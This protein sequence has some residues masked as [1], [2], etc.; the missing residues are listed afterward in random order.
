MF[1]KQVD[2]SA[3]KRLVY[4]GADLLVEWRNNKQSYAYKNV[5]NEVAIKVATAQSVGKAL[6]DEIKK[7]FEFV[8]LK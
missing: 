5:P 7:K 1:D 6:N 4:N 8:L 3:V 2:S